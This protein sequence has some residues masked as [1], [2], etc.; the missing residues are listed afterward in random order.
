MVGMSGS[1][2]C[3]RNAVHRRQPVRR[4][5]ALHWPTP[6][7][8]RARIDLRN[9]TS[10]IIVFCS[11]GDDIT[12]PPQALDWILDLYDHEDEIIANGQTI[13][14]ALHQTIGHLGIFVSGQVA[15]KEDAELVQCM[16]LIDLLPPDSMRQ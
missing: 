1:D 6:H 14:Y 2:E 10:P 16:D 4:E 12:P 8:G 13:V 15:T 3:G 5:Q 9:I 11:W 7:I